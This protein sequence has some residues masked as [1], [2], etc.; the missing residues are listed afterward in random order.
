MFGG[1]VDKSIMEERKRILITGA[2]SGIGKV[3]A[4]ELVK[5]GHQ[6]VIHGRSGAKAEAAKKEILAK[7]PGGLVDVLLA[8]LTRKAD[9]LALVDAFNDR[10]DALDVLV[11]NAGGVMR[12]QREVTVDGWEQT[13]AVNVLAPFMLSALLYPKMQNQLDARIVNTASMAHRMA[14]PDLTD[15]MYEKRYNA[16]K[17][18][19]DAKLYVILMGQEF[20]RRQA[21]I[22]GAVTMNSFHPGVVATNFAGESD[23]LYHF[24]FSMF[25]PLLITPEK[26]ADTLIYLA[27]HPDAGNLNG[28]YLAKRKKSSVHGAK[29]PKLAGQLWERWMHYTGIEFF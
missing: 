29:N 17:A 8:D 18:Y 1:G 4:L 13:I 26:G 15:L 23:S 12:K 14:K 19:G 7:V 20:A 9:I 22:G 27:S 5:Q 21:G 28:E 16:M 2:T 11:N 3:A 6:V 24:F 25:R 10:Y